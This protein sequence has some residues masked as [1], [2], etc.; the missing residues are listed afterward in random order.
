VSALQDDPLSAGIVAAAGV[1]VVLMHAPGAGGGSGLHAGG[2]YRNILLDV[3]DWLRD[4]RDQALAAGIAPASIVLDPGIGFGKSLAGNLA[5]MNGLALFHGLGHPLLVGASRKRM[6]GAL[7]GEAPADRRLGGSVALALSAMMAGCQ[8]LRVH[9][10]FETVQARDVWLGL[11]DGALAEV[12]LL[13][14]D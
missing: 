9:D 14:G 8:I 11:R 2:D 3:F 12:A 6:I 7:H 4:A 10:V 5:L 1:P 13:P